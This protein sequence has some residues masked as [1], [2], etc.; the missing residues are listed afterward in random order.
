M[1]YKEPQIINLPPFTYFGED[2]DS[3]SLLKKIIF[4]FKGKFIGF[5][6]SNTK[7]QYLALYF[8]YFL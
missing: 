6:V 5:V 7:N 2:I 4:I 3:Y 1:R 8:K